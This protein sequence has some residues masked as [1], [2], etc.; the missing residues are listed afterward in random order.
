MTFQECHEATRPRPT[1]LHKDRDTVTVRF[2]S[3]DDKSFEGAVAD[4]ARDK[5]W[6]TTTTGGYDSNR[7]AIVERRNSKLQAGHRA[8]LC[9]GN[10]W[11]VVL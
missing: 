4:C 10:W 8:L 7:N 3:D 2:H 9:G 5:A 6:L 1:L 11:K